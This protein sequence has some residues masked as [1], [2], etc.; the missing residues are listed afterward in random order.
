MA[1]ARRRI[2]GPAGHTCR[3]RRKQDFPFQS[4]RNI[5]FNA[6][7]DGLQTLSTA[8]Y[9]NQK[10]SLKTSTNLVEIEW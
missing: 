1:T 3:Q 5:Y 7:G 2:S 10:N 4:E 8:P 6:T 9:S